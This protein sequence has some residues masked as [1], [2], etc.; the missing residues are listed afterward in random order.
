[1]NLTCQIHRG[2]DCYYIGCKL[3]V[4]NPAHIWA[5]WAVLLLLT[6][7]HLEQCSCCSHLSTSSS[8]RY[9][10]F[11]C[12]HSP[13]RLMLNTTPPL[14]GVCPQTSSPCLTITL[15]S[16]SPLLFTVTAWPP[17]SLRLLKSCDL[18]RSVFLNLFPATW[19]L[20]L[21]NA[22]NVWHTLSAS[23]IWLSLRL[24]ELMFN[25][26]TLIFIQSFVKLSPVCHNCR[27]NLTWWK[28]IEIRWFSMNFRT[29]KSWRLMKL[30][31]LLR[32]L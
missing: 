19:V 29:L 28:V 24:S 4:L 10:L 32:Q 5:P 18:I 15:R 17:T 21:S 23:V 30:M 7:K 25:R 2:F 11:S 12:I 26:N 27:G 22:L 14:W 1:M 20:N 9:T 13:V 16:S 6:L 8:T 31:R 3:S